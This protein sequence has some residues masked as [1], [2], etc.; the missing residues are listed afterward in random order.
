MASPNSPGDDPIL[1]RLEPLP[2]SWEPMINTLH[3][4]I[5]IERDDVGWLA[6]FQ[7]V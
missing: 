1:V 5:M 2:Y 3:L 4:S 7:R 6:A